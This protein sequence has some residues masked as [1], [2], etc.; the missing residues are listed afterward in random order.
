MRRLE[1]SERGRREWLLTDGAGGYAMGCFDGHPRR[2]YHSYCTTAFQQPLKRINVLGFA[3]EEILTRTD[4]IRLFSH[5]TLEFRHHEGATVLE[6]CVEWTH[7]V[8]LEDR[9]H[10]VS[11]QLR[12]IPGGGCELSYRIEPPLKTGMRF[13]VR[14]VFLLR[15]HHRMHGVEVHVAPP[16]PPRRSDKGNWRLAT[17]IQDFPEITMTLNHAGAKL[18]TENKGFV[19]AYDME[20]ERGF[21]MEERVVSTFCFE[22]GY[23]TNDLTLRVEPVART[24]SQGAPQF[25]SAS[26][27]LERIPENDPLRSW[28]PRL[29]RSA[30]AFL[31]E[32]RRAPAIIAGYPWYAVWARETFISLP[33][34]CL[35]TGETETARRVL[36]HFAEGMDRGV[37]RNRLATT[38]V[39][40][41]QSGINRDYTHGDV[42]LWFL[43]AAAQY[44]EYSR[45]RSFLSEY[46]NIVEDVV[47]WYSRGTHGSIRVDQDGLIYAGSYNIP[48][49]WMNGQAGSHCMTQRA[50]KPIEINALW[51]SVLRLWAG[52]AQRSLRSGLATRLN[53]LAEQANTSFSNR[54]WL[55]HYRW[56][57]DVLESP[58]VDGYRDDHTLRPNQVIALS[59]PEVEVPEDQRRA[60]LESCRNTLLVP[61]GLRTLAPQ[62]SRYQ[63][64]YEGSLGA[65]EFAMHNGVSWP[66]LLGRYLTA[67]RIAW[68]REAV[69]NDQR[70]ILTE[71]MRVF[72]QDTQGHLA[73]MYDSELPFT[74]RGC[75]AHAMGVAE[76]LRFLAEDYFDCHDE[77]GL[78]NAFDDHK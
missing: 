41:G 4:T 18:I 57:A 53:R 72:G 74:A 46:L 34:L 25:R 64:I 40:P 10:T 69:R 9:V 14:P 50:G 63:P 51:I 39:V 8:E 15:S 13:R 48:L 36:D 56:F 75:P 5:D 24:L 45:D 47:N 49:T 32:G 73:E 58:S 7:E 62:D 2:K 6:D 43:R 30:R 23:R 37:I 21:P 67:L 76:M 28:I 59:F 66:W 11:K 17:G 70:A 16:A 33:G 22:V 19:A 77:R 42:T 26:S 44:V 27:L 31:V 3:E 78:Q 71:V 61:L 12:L 65:R 29:E 55:P 60:A 52:L 54:Y 1:D 20:A 68:G 38:P 35:V